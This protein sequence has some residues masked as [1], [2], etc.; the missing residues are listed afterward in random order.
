MVLVS[1]SIHEA[2]ISRTFFG[3]LKASRRWKLKKLI[4]LENIKSNELSLVLSKIVSK[5]LCCDTVWGFQFFH[6]A[7]LSVV[8][9]ESPQSG[10]KYNKSWVICSVFWILKTLWRLWL[11][12]LNE[13]TIFN[14]TIP[15]WDCVS[16][17]VRRTYQKIPRNDLQKEMNEAFELITVIISLAATAKRKQLSNCHRQTSSQCSHARYVTSRNSSPRIWDGGKKFFHAVR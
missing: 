10:E 7:H 8:F 5:G 2:R 1:V 14:P 9:T 16:L 17:R 6:L 12:R 4:I 13:L 3:G 11:M 15:T